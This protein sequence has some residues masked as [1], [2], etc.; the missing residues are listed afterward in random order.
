VD[1]F[2]CVKP[3]SQRFLGWNTDSYIND[4]LREMVF[5]S[6]LDIDDRNKS[7]NVA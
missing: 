2:P 3:L 7:Q 1:Q 5:D 6:H 4:L